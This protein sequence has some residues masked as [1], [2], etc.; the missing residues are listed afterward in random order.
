MAT[1]VQ[2]SLRNWVLTLSNSSGD[3]LAFV[4]ALRLTYPILASSQFAQSFVKLIP[5]LSLVA[6]W[7]LWP[8]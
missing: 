4:V 5:P 8:K 1:I 2:I 3:T 6:N 7:H